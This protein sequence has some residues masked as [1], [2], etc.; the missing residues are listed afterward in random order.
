MIVVL[1]TAWTAGPGERSDSSCCG[2]PP[3]AVLERHDLYNEALDRLDRWA[4]AAAVADLLEVE[5]VTYWFRMRETLWHWLH[6]RL[7]WRYAL[8][9]VGCRRA[10]RHRLRAVDRGC[11]DRRRPGPRSIDRDPGRVGVDAGPVQPDARQAPPMRQ[12]RQD[13]RAR[14]GRRAGSFPPRSV[15]SSGGS[16]PGPRRPRQRSAVDESPSST[17]DSRGCRPSSR[18][19]S[20]C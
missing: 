18:H 17:S 8:A 6:E 12:M 15:A 3:A 9:G 16:V 13:R 10:C 1:D 19:A 2:L 5:G 20:S 11:P 14:H 7:L 4:E